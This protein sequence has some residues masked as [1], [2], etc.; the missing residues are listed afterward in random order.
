MLL[1]AIMDPAAAE[2]AGYCR[3]KYFIL[4]YEND[5]HLFED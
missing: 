2:P 4:L 5:E 3:T 1:E